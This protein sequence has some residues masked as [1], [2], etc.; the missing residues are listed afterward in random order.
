ME[1]TI[2]CEHNQWV[3]CQWSR[4]GAYDTFQTFL[5]FII[6]IRFDTKLE[7]H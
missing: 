3:V 1:K 7:F 5:N 2:L 6:T 4:D